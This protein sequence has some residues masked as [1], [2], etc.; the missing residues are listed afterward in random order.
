MNTKNILIN[1]AQCI[2]CGSVV[3][4]ICEDHRV[5]CKCRAL[6]ISG[7]NTALIRYNNFGV[8]VFDPAIMG[9]HYFEMSV[10]LLQE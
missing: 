5:Q 8:G 3:E 6:S 1:K 9:V 4:S 10:F 2:E 7:G